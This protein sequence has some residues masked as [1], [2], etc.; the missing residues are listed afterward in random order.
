M[1]QFGWQDKHIRSSLQGCIYMAP[2]N[3]HVDRLMWRIQWVEAGRIEGKEHCIYEANTEL[4]LTF[5]V[6]KGD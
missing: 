3:I 4:G 5:S 2:V 6:Y 1:L